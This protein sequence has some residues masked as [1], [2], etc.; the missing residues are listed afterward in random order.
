MRSFL[1][2]CIAELDT[3]LRVVATRAG[4]SAR[5]VPAPADGSGATDA[6]PEP[7]SAASAR[8][9]ARL[10]RVNHSGEIAAQALYRGQAFVARDAALRC[11]LLQAA[12]EEHD[13]LAWCEARVTELGERTSRLGP[14]WY[15]GSF[16]IGALAGLAGD[17]ISFGF[18]AETEKL[19]VEH[20]D[21]HLSRL[22]RSDARSRCI[23]AQM[24]QD[25]AEHQDSAL[26]HGGGT[27]PPP[28]R[29]AM[30]ATARI[31]TSLSYWL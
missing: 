18:L 6:G 12:E 3:A 23:V 10:M 25:E 8:D 9:A 31:M 5:P 20:L 30:R 1:D 7:I 2:S 28:V 24:R 26:Q 17:R 27:L 15:G 19:V 11:R 14:L 22:P 16:T 29:A 4:T 13:H 21:G